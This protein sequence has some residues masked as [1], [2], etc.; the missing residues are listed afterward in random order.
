M[1]LAGV[2]ASF[3]PAAAATT[4]VWTGAGGSANWSDP[5]NWQSAHVPAPGD[6]I[7]FPAGAMQ[8][9]NND[10]LS[11]GPFATLSSEGTDYHLSGN[12]L[13]LSG[14]ITLSPRQGPAIWRIDNPVN[15][16]SSAQTLSIAYQGRLIL[17]GPLTGNGN[18]T[19]SGADLEL[20][21]VSPGLTGM[22]D[23][24]IAAVTVNGSAPSLSIILTQGAVIGVSGTIQSPSGPGAVGSLTS[25]AGN[26]FGGLLYLGAFGTPKSIVANGPVALDNRTQVNSHAISNTDVGQVVLA[27][28]VNIDLGSAQT[29]F[30]F[31]PTQS[32]SSR[33]FSVLSGSYTLVRHLG[34]G[35]TTGV[36]VGFE[37][38]ASVPT[39][40]GGVFN[41]TYHGGQNG[42]DVV[43]TY[44]PPK[45]GYWLVAR[46]GGVFPFGSAK[47]F[48]SAADM[49]LDS[50]VVGL[51]QLPGNDG[52][53]VAT[54]NGKVYAFSASLDCANSSG[55]QL[56]QPIV[57]ITMDPAN[58][59]CW[60]VAA[61]GGVFPSRYA[62]GLG[63]AAGMHLNAAIVGM[64][65][66]PD[67]GGYWLV[68]AD[69]GIFPFGNA[70]GFGSTAGSHLN[71][72]II[73]MART[74]D[75]GGY[76]LAAS[77]GG[78][79]PLGDARGFGSLGGS[80]LN[81]PVVG[82]AATLD[83]GGYW[84]VAA[85]GGVFPF[86]DAGGFGGTGGMQLNQPIVGIA[87]IG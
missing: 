36:L 24:G 74:P 30:Y 58:G 79:F 77:D 9:S 47:G 3:A 18:L 31:S 83:G 84:L 40:G 41:V 27:P 64:V 44:V 25:R 50:P 26:A 62:P 85:D 34:Q 5:A 10:D 13:A 78:V 65:P 76:W 39:S 80:V 49:H 51:G 67:G 29:L 1:A 82:I 52:Y 14:G 81:K 63:S 15:F 42:H 75:G 23:T 33:K 21:G 43:L 38:G 19:A 60:L 53:D 55:L 56:N 35:S 48:G 68:A 69:G 8:R 57:G 54:A 4:A 45:Q 70:A 16:G 73:G 17:A 12:S 7:D 46:D 28:G 71:A 37:D 20:D 61:D 87:A 32:P 6:S 2:A 11:V 86:G 72:P 22:L 59:E 66:T